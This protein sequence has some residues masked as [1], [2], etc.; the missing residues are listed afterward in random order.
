MFATLCP[1]A[2]IVRTAAFGGLPVNVGLEAIDLLLDAALSYL[3][4]AR[5]GPT[6]SYSGRPQSD[7]ES[8]LVS[9]LM[10]VQICSAGTT[11]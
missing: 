10:C 7:L 1:I 3:V 6:G 9:A 8:Q 5:P 11:G 2:G 4:Q